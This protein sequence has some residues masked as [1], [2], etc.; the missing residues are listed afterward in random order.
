MHHP[1]ERMIALCFPPQKKI[2]GCLCVL[3][4]SI[5]TEYLPS[6]T[7]DVRLDEKEVR[8]LPAIRGDSGSDPVDADTTGLTAEERK[9]GGSVR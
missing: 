5:N 1:L 9:L 7:G 6:D 4:N 3:R 8:I 2:P